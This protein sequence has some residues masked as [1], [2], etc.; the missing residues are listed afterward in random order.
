MRLVRQ[1]TALTLSLCLSLVDGIPGSM[2]AAEVTAYPGA[3][4]VERIENLGRLLFFDPNLSRNRTQSC[5]SCHDPGTGFAD[6]RGRDAARAVSLGDDG[7]SLGDRNA[8]TAAYA[9]F[10]PSFHRT[11]EGEY[12]G[13]QFLDGRASDLATQAGGPPLN[14]IEMGMPDKAHM[15]SR[16]RKSPVYETTFP[17]LFGADIWSQPERAYGAMTDAIAAFERTAFFAP[18]DSKYDRYLK[19]EYEMTTEESLGMTLFFSSQFTNCH[20]CHQ[21]N[22]MPGTEGETFTNYQFHNIGVPVNGAIRAINGRPAGFRDEGL[23]GNPAVEDRE[24]TIGRFKT[25]TLRNVAVTGPYMHNGVF[26]DLRTVILFYNKYN[27]RS[28]KRQVNPETGVAWAEPE[29]AANLSIEELETGPALDDRRIDALV[30][31]LKTL[32]DRR[33]EHPVAEP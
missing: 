17:G 29:V 33:Y 24:K 22:E 3:A 30:A 7:R 19:G 16:L 28:P 18:F 12:V 1:R 9:C 26:R 5:A 6:P 27:S 4:P 20:L 2:A 31:F 8:P 25:P 11:T 10:S 21:L 15:V 32:T 23:A 14:P 13:G